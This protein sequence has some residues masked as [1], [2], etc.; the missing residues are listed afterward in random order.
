MLWY[1]SWKT[2]PHRRY[3]EDSFRLRIQL[4]I[5]TK[6]LLSGEWQPPRSNFQHLTDH[7]QL[8]TRWIYWGL[9]C[10][11][12]LN[13]CVKQLPLWHF[14]SY[15]FDWKYGSAIN[16][17][18]VI[19]S[20]YLHKLLQKEILFIRFFFS[21]VTLRTKIST[22]SESEI[23]DPICGFWTSFERLVLSVNILTAWLGNKVTL[24]LKP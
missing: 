4:W 5:N 6:L 24:N 1:S 17:R 18:C 20:L 13:L 7:R 12:S 2:I 9:F 11:S 22:P 3:Q 14:F 19:F 10:D 8:L 15:Q 23:N 16:G 21:N